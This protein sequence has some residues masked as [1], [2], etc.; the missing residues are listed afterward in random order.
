MN[1]DKELLNGLETELL[2][3]LAVDCYSS[4]GRRRIKAIKAKIRKVKK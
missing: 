1:K 2:K 4:A 3:A